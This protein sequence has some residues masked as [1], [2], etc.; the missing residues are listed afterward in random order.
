MTKTTALVVAVIAG[1]VGFSAPA[2]AE[3]LRKLSGPQI[4]AKLI[5]MQF[6][7][8]VHWGE[9]YWPDGRLTSE[10]MGRKRVGKWR[11]EKDQICMD[12]GKDAGNTCY[13]VWISG[14]KVQ[15][16]TPGSSDSPLEG[17]LEKA[18]NRR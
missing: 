14:R 10:E 1:S 9:V 15:M 3:S 13:E 11:I 5:G 8:E 4:R 18:P 12:Y 2:S 6:T 16:R 7:D 17:V